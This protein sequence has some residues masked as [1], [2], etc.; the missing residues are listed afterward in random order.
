M[1]LGSRA[2]HLGLWMR[3]SRTPGL[4]CLGHQHHCR[5]TAIMD[6]ASATSSASWIASARA[7]A[8][9]WE[10]CSTKATQNVALAL[11]AVAGA[12]IGKP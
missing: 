5:A 2:N 9:R 1:R 10:I 4:R 11:C 3:R 6:L 12:W 8:S 7:C